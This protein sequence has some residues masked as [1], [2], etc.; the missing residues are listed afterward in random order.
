MT[1]DFD[2]QDFSGNSGHDYVT[3][4]EYFLFDTDSDSDKSDIMKL[5]S[6]SIVFNI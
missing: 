6:K 3:C 4:S 1:S 5:K 2:M